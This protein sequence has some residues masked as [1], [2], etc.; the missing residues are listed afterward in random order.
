MVGFLL[1]FNMSRPPQSPVDF[2]KCRQALM[3]FH[4]LGRIGMTHG[5]I[6]MDHFIMT[7]TV[8]FNGPPVIKAMLID[9][10]KAEAAELG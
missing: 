7:S 10:S 1:S 6:K 5:A 8:R 3:A 4:R 9:Y 2:T